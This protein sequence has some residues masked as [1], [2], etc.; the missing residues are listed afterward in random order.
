MRHATRVL[1]SEWT[2]LRSVRA[3]RWTLIAAVLI[4]AGLS[5]LICVFTRADF[6]NMSRRSQATFDATYV[7]FT[8]MG[9]G[10]LAMMAFGVLVVSAEYS[11]GMIRS[12]L[13]AVPQRGLFLVCKVAVATGLVF[14]VGQI[15][16]FGTFYLGQWLLGSHS[17]GITEPGVLRA[18]VGA[19]LYMT[20]IG[21]FAMGLTFVL[22]SPVVS[23]IV[24]MPFFFIV[25]GIL[26]S[27][28]ATQK[29]AH[30]LPDQAGTTIMAV[31]PQTLDRPY[32][33]WGGLLIMVGWTAAALVAGYFVLRERDA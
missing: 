21:L 5:A 31:V 15:T 23:F 29:I 12:S 17:V 11:T 8:G 19:G 20:L 27:V 7:S 6:D 26:S 32:G 4:T 10:Q 18:V 16:G 25:S 1:R 2:K 24:L 3:T 28:G 14:V 22:R 13:S 9:I 30:Y 33:P